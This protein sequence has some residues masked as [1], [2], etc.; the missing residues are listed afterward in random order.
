MPQKPEI[1]TGYLGQEKNARDVVKFMAGFTKISD[2]KKIGV[3]PLSTLH[4]FS[5][6]R[7]RW[8]ARVLPVWLQ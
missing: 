7:I 3:R 5:F 1:D 6:Q 8:L 4:P 2:I